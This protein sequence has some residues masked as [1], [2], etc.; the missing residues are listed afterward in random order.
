[1]ES[2]DYYRILGVA[3][4]ASPGEI[5]KAYKKLA[6]KFHPDLNPG[7]KASENRFKEISEAY[8]VLSDLKK[9]E[10]YDRF[11]TASDFGPGA[12]GGGGGAG[13]QSYG[14]EGF[15]FTEGA[16]FGS[17]SFRDIF[18]EIF[19]NPFSK[20]EAEEPGMQRGEDIQHTM[21]LSFEDAMHGITTRIQITKL[22]PC[23]RCSGSGT[24]GGSEKACSLCSGT[25]K[26]HMQK[27]HM[28]FTT[29]C[30]RCG[31]SGRERGANC[32]ECH[33]DGRHQVTEPL[34]V[35]IPAGVDNGSKVRIPGKGHAG[36]GGAPPGDLYIITNVAAHPSFTREGDNIYCT[37]PITITEAAL[38]T[39]IDVP[40]LDGVA[41]MR[42]PPG[43]QSGQRFR[44]REHGAHSLRT[45]QR[46]DQFVEVKIVMPQV[47]DERSKEILR[48]FA[49]LNPENPRELLPS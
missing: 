35:R 30:N 24:E 9:R 2:K 36:R 21:N 10:K 5:K 31:G 43:T 22:E 26:I 19:R 34:R 13:P 49:R 7:D 38:G 6:R 20:K 41:T 1:M 47:K 25:G 28:R 3:R 17:T 12:G 46:G 37:V 8:D 40:T 11:G 4:G 48:E 44:L 33:G 15:D 29:A 32:S 39:K 18:S 45:N 27:G 23:A 16:P 42:I 14:F